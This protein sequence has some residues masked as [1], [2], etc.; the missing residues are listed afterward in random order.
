MSKHLDRKDDASLAL[1]C[2]PDG[3][4]T[5][6]LH[7]S[8]GLGEQMVPGRPLT[9]IL[10]SGSVD[11]SRD[12]LK[13][14]Q[15][16]GA[17]SGW[18]M[19]VLADAGI[20]RLFFLGAQEEDHLAI[21]GLSTPTPLALS[22]FLR[23]LLAG[24]DSGD[25]AETAVR[26][27]LSRKRERERDL[28]P[29]LTRLNKELQS[30]QRDLLRK[31]RELERLNEEKSLLLQLAAHDLRQP[32]GAILVYS[33]LLI[34]QCESGM[35]DER[36][37]FINAIHSS[38]ESMLRLLDDVLDFSAVESNTLAL[39]AEPASLVEILE[40]SISVSLPL[41]QKKRIQLQLR[42]KGPILR[43]NVDRWK[44]QEVFNILIRNAIKH[45]E[46]AAAIEVGVTLKGDR[47]IVSVR[48]TGP[49]IPPDELE[50]LFTPFQKTRARAATDKPL[51]LAIAKRIVNRHGG[52]IWAKSSAGAGATFYVSLPFT[53]H[54][55]AA[56]SRN[57][58]NRCGL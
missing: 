50:S 16:E 10:E 14:I 8:L 29:Y 34:E 57:I 17:V 3:F 33:E 41:A 49:G 45:S 40:H 32:L 6:V 7:D 4:V 22:L 46:N 13:A 1:L 56:R 15:D 42:H 37:E 52:E 36:Q 20:V 47:A 25:V 27:L 23:E 55:A 44:M 11:K 30:A 58:L 31:N 48:D 18:E 35:S 21:V 38:S 51:E 26:A 24:R 19:D 28:Y 43:V 53:P 2:S 9:T 5:Q 54:P 12:F 39:I